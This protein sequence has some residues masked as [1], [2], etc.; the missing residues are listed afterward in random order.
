MDHKHFENSFIFIYIL[1]V[2]M[3]AG[4]KAISVI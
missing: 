1:F 2:V 3:K 4:G